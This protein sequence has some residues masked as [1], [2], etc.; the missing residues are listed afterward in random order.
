MNRFFNFSDFAILSKV[1]IRGVSEYMKQTVTKLPQVSAAIS[2]DGVVLGAICVENRLCIEAESIGADLRAA[3]L[4]AEDKRFL[5]HTGVDWIAVA[6]ACWKNIKAR[7]VAQG[8]STITQQLVR[9][10]IL[11]NI[12]KTVSRK[13]LE[14]CFALALEKKL[15]KQQILAGYL[16]AAYFG[17]GIYG[18]KLAALYYLS[19]EVDEL[20]VND[21]AYLAGLLRGP[22]RY[23]RCCNNERSARRTKYVLNRMVHNGYPV[24]NIQRKPPAHR[25]R[26][27][28]TVESMCPSTVPYFL[29]FVRQRLLQ[30]TPEHFPCR[31]LIVRTSL[32]FRCQEVLEKVCRD[33]EQ[34][35]FTGRL[36]CIV[37]DA[38]SG[39]VRALAGGYNFSQQPFNVAVNGSVQPGSTFKPFVLAAAMKAGISPEKRY[40]SQPLELQLPDNQIWRVGNF[41]RFY[42]GEI[43]LAEALV[44]SDNSVFAQ[45]M[46]ELGVDSFAGL[47]R[48]V[49]LD[50]G[51]VSPA[52]A[53]GAV[54]R[55]VSPLQVCSSYSLFSTE[56]LFMPSSPILSVQSESGD[57]LL[58]HVQAFQPVLNPSMVKT[59]NQMLRQVVLRGTGALSIENND[60]HAKTGTTHD[61][62][63]YA[64]FDPASRVLTWVERTDDDRVINYPEKGTTARN[65]AERIW[66]LLRR[67]SYAST[68]L[69]GVFR[70]ADH[71]NVRDLLWM[72]EQFA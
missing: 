13:F 25:F 32:N 71:L 50:A 3:I 19:K 47:L 60:I 14:I 39:L 17:H 59:I 16:N 65:L 42:R 5:S 64:S 49:G 61:G 35:G 10:A 62:A 27:R 28:R 51:P 54:T 23:C 45:L 72:E 29:D 37:Q 68:Q 34:E 2:E 30:C 24:R 67:G 41:Q 40:L 20:T 70:G 18:V 4:S 36:A 56:G 12:R 53:I 1:P 43:T 69:Y 33:V 38:N 63:W 8:G 9:N 26:R 22:S 52:A 57:V 15:T 46:V 11:H 58:R 48:R 7:R 31:S 21:C 55:G 66:S 6:R 44:F